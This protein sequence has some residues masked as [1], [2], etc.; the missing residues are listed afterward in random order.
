M[1]WTIVYGIL[2]YMLGAF[3]LSFYITSQEVE[4]RK[5]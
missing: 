1:T 4:K 5:S 3:A 2:I